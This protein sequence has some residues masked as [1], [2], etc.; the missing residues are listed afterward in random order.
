M[1]TIVE[2]FANRNRAHLDIPVIGDSITYGQGATSWAN[3]WVRQANNDIRANWPTTANGSNGGL[4]FIA[5]GDSYDGEESFTY[6]VSVTGNYGTYLD[7]GA[8][9]FCGGFDNFGALWAFVAPAGTTSVRIS[10]FDGNTG[11]G[12]QY[13]VNDGSP[14]TIAFGETFAEILT[15]SIPM[16]SGDTLYVYANTDSGAYVDGLIHYAGDENCGIT[17]QT[18]GR[19]G[20]CAG[21]ESDIGWNQPENIDNFNWAQAF[22]NG[23]QNTVALAFYLGVNDAITDEGNRTAAEFQSDLIGLITTVQNADASLA[24]LPILFIA[25]YE[26]DGTFADPDGWPAYVAAIQNVA[27]AYPDSVV[28]NL[29]AVMEPVADDPG[30]YYDGYHPNDEGHALIGGYV[31]DAFPAPAPGLLMAGDYDRPG[32]LRKPF[33]W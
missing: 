15:D 4:G 29:S 2:A 31:A 26:V 24:N 13:Y 17:L 11:A 20:W 30:Y 14:V 27:A 10:Y 18:C 23:F 25:S 12:F 32:L 21:T 1:G 22:A 19:P 28:V 8:I 3:G 16:N 9:R 33:L 6:P 7:L 5:F